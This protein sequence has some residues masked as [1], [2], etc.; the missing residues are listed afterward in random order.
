MTIADPTDPELTSR[1]EAS[2]QGHGRWRALLREPRFIVGGGLVLLILAIAIL[3]PMLAPHAADDYVGVPFSSP[4]DGY[5]L[6][7]D[8]KGQDIWSRFLRGGWTVVWMS[9]A[10]ATIGTV[11]GT[12]LGMLAGYTRGWFDEVAMRLVDVWLAFPMIVFVL[13][14]VSM[15]GSGLWLLVLLIGLAHIPQVTRVVRGVTLDVGTR[16]FVESAKVLGSG[17]VRTCVVQILPNILPT[18]LVEYGIRVVWSVGTIAS[19]GVLGM[20]IKAPYADWGLMINENQPGLTFAP[21]GVLLPL[22]G[23]AT[24]AIG[25][26]VLSEGISRAFSVSVPGEVK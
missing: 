14:F 22:A 26:N 21:L 15:A 24:F 19:L 10:S 8:V 16:E 23:I 9:I 5:P 25:F 13:L 2:L 6:G 20:G 7:T 3:G 18:V 1:A 12:F 4:G 17:V 11:A